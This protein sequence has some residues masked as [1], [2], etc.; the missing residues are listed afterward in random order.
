MN[1]SGGFGQTLQNAILTQRPIVTLLTDF[2]TTDGFIGVMKG[3]MLQIAP[4]IHFVDISHELPSF[5]IESAAF[6]NAWS[7][8]YFPPGALHLCVVDPGVGSSRRALVVETQGHTFI[9]PDNGLLTPVLTLSGDKIIVS[10]AKP[11][12]WLSKI[13]NTFHGRDVFAPLA[14]HVARGA[15]ITALGE[16]IS[17]PVLVHT[18][19]PVFTPERIECRIQYIDHFGNLVTNLTQP[20][21]DQWTQQNGYDKRRVVIQSGDVV[22]NGI[23]ETYSSQNP[24]ELTAVFDGYDCLEIAVTQGNAAK[25]LQINIGQKVVIQPAAGKGA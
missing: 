7:Y 14:A 15:A 19:P 8:G 24:G 2:G 10:A 12:Y 5:S 21:F 6:L 25:H 16:E 11:E 17:D 9:A 20:R 4:D 1:N 23:S 3:V 18:P 22:I 13:S